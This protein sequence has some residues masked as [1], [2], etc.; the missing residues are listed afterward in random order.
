MHL[1][2]L[3]TLILSAALGCAGCA[4]TTQPGAVGVDRPQLVA[5]PTGQMEALAETEYAKQLDALRTAGKLIETGPDLERVRAVM[6]RLVAQVAAFR[7]DATSWNWQVKLANSTEINAGCLYGGRMLVNTGL[8]TMLGSSDDELAAIMG[9]EMAHALREHGREKT[10]LAASRELM[11]LALRTSLGRSVNPLF[12]S[13][14]VQDKAM[15]LLLTLPHS[16][17]AELEADRI[18]LEL[19]AR[20]GYDPAAALTVWR[21]MSQA[22]K[23]ISPWLSTH[24]APDAR[25][26]M[27]ESLLPVVRPL[28]EAAQR[29]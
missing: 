14:D 3:R 15:D 29:P 5:I 24:P 22:S 26:Q 4:Q 17:E 12:R 10:T 13:S 11:K 21:K 2:G 1:P 28:Q 16:R 6:N 9:H 25:L 7:A 19:M 23:V 18:G 8:L 27:L 20:A